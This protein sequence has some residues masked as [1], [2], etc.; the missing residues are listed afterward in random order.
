MKRSLEIPL[1]QKAGSI[2][3]AQFCDW[4]LIETSPPDQDIQEKVG[5]RLADVVLIFEDG[6][7][8]A[9]PIRR[10]YEVNA[11]SVEWGHLSFLSFAQGADAPR[12]LTDPLPDAKDWGNLQ[13]GFMDNSYSD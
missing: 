5:Q 12:Q 4:D 6:R 7:Q 11:P 13:M 2:C 9:L 1:K 10:R 8:E 3:L